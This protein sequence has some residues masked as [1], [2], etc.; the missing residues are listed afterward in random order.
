MV[1]PAFLLA[2]AI[3]FA[4]AQSFSELAADDSP[5]RHQR[6]VE[7]ARKE[8]ALTV[9]TSNAAPT[10]EVLSADFEKRYGV[11][12]NAWRASSAKVLQRA[13]TEKRA[14]RWD[15]D[16]VSVSSPELEALYRENLL[17]EI[18]SGW[19]KEMLEGT[20]PAHR[21]WAPQFINV[22]VQAYNTRA[23]K[24]EELPK[25]WDD[26]LDPRWRGKLGAEAKAG[27]WYCGL[28]RNLGEE[29]GAE[30]F[31][32]IAARNGLSVRSGNSVLANMVVSGEVP[33]ALAVYSHMIEEARQ[34]GAP[35]DWIAIDPMIGRSNGIGVSRRPPHPNAALLFYEYAIGDAQP[36]M[37]KM[38]YLSPLRKLASPLRG[39][40]ILF[41]DPAAEGAQVERCD[42]AYDALIKTK[43]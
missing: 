33:F 17:Q 35:V 3:P 25:R 18:D 10:I 23:V 20:M 26:L 9:Y 27:E 36:L 39:A 14:N 30:L 24:K 11:R 15:F 1:I 6:L 37:L 38:N 29:K 31:R 34:Q 5:S 13:L 28:L 2:V 32:E 12:V 42:N 43:K 7:A 40:R 22:F 19:H 4:A 41:V 8:G 16:A 21:G